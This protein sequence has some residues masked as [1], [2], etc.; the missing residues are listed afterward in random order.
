MTGC[1]PERLSLLSDEWALVRTGR[2]SVADYLELVSGFGGETE[3]QVLG[4][5]ETSV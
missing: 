1:A 4:V 2:H 5:A 3:A